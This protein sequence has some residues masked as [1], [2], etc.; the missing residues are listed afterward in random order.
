MPTVCHPSKR[1][2]HMRPHDKEYNYN[3]VFFVMGPHI[4]I[5][6]T[7]RESMSNGWPCNLC[8]LDA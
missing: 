8:S 5:S 2:G 6:K 7:G 1:S 4:I 3:I